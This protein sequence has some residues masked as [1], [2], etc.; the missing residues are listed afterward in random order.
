MAGELVTASLMNT[1]V[2]D[3]LNALRATPANSCSAYHNT[4]QSVTDAV[5][6]LN[7]EEAD[8]ASM[9]DLVTNNNRITIPSGGAGR[10]LIN[11]QTTFASNAAALQVRLNGTAIRE[12]AQTGGL[13]FVNV[14][15]LGYL[16]AAADYVEMFA[17]TGGVA[18]TAGSATARLATRLEVVGPLPPA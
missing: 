17:S 11:A 16:L 1:H 3:N 18:S 14:V 6:N 15:L 2:R 9:H 12:A 7:A 4:T 5:L 10:Y 8:T 13:G